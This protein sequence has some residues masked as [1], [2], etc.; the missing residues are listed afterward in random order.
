MVYS[1]IQY[2]DL[3][4]LKTLIHKRHMN[5]SSWLLIFPTYTIYWIVW[6]FFKPKTYLVHSNQKIFKSSDILDVC[7]HYKYGPKYILTL[8]SANV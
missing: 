5:M 8:S 2:P 1:S 6:V 7:G 4:D 3:L